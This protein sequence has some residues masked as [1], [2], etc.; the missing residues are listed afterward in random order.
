ME[1]GWVAV[2]KFSH[3]RKEDKRVRIMDGSV[4]GS[5]KKQQFSQVGLISTFVLSE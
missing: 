5:R 1:R 2:E 3:M 4:A